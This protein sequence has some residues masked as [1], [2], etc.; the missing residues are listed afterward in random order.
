MYSAKHEGKN[1]YHFFTQTM[2]EAAM[3]RMR[4]INDLR[5]ALDQ[6]QIE[7]VYQPIV[8]LK[9]GCISKAAAL[10]RWQHPT[11]GMASPDVF[12]SA[13]EETGLIASL[14]N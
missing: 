12:V 14:G 1:R 10:M 3:D 2:Q 11:R 6:G 7:I 13:A 4:L 5:S 9:T 8:E